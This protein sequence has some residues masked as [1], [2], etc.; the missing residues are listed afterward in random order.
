MLDHIMV[1]FKLHDALMIQMPTGT[2]K[3]HVLTSVVKAFMQIE[4]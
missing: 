4:Q 3:T 2:G 1:A